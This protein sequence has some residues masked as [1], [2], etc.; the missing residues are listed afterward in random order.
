M[1]VD[2]L[3]HF[4]LHI[5]SCSLLIISHPVWR[6]SLIF[7]SLNTKIYHRF[8]G[9]NNYASFLHFF[10]FPFGSILVVTTFSSKYADIFLVFLILLIQSGYGLSHCS[11][12]SCDI[13]NVRRVFCFFH[14]FMSIMLLTIWFTILHRV[15]LHSC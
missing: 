9:C 14:R 5:F 10:P 11:F 8:I 1:F 7:C 4:P 6:Y 2:G 15:S 3:L 13:L 12:Y